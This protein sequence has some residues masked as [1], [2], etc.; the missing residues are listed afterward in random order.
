MRVIT[1]TDEKDAAILIAVMKECAIKSLGT[2]DVKLL[3]KLGY[4][5]GTISANN[6]NKFISLKQSFF[7]LRRS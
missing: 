5:T 4:Y 6:W 2:A 1:F 3:N 7:Y